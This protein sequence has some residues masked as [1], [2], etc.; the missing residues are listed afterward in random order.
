MTH[1]DTLSRQYGIRSEHTCG[2]T[3]HI[4]KSS[5]RS[6]CG[7]NSRSISS[8]TPMMS[9][10]YITCVDDVCGRASSIYNT[11]MPRLN[12]EHTLSALVAFSYRPTKIQRGIHHEAHRLSLL[13][14]NPYIFYIRIGWS[15]HID[16]ASTYTAR[17]RFTIITTHIVMGVWVGELSLGQLRNRIPQER[18]FGIGLSIIVMNERIHTMLFSRLPLE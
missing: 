14:C 9:L 2:L 4:V 6:S 16:Y 1:L 11:N 13:R 5:R 3:T 12:V 18:W 7:M 10:R 17:H 8:I 15:W